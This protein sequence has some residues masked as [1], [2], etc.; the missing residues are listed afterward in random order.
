MWQF[1]H[2]VAIC[3]ATMCP[4][5]DASHV[6]FKPPRETAMC[7]EVNASHVCFKSPC[8]ATTCPEVNASH[9]CFNCERIS[10]QRPMPLT[11]VSRRP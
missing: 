6:C 1:V 9:A 3:E 5:V 2:I 10:V 8:G 11:S 4:E 7:P